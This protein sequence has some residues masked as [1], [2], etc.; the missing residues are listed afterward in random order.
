M[1]IRGALICISSMSPQRP[2]FCLA[3]KYCGMVTHKRRLTESPSPHVTLA[4][5]VL[6]QLVQERRQLTD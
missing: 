4:F 2:Y 3:T 5:R 6:I 1:L